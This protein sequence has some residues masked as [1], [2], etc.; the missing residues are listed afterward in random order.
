MKQSFP[1][2]EALTRFAQDVAMALKPGDC[3]LLRGD[4][5]AGKSTFARAAIRMLAGDPAGKLEVPS[6]TFTLVQTYDLRLPVSHFDLYR[7]GDPDE[8]DELGLTDA[9]AEGVALV[10]WPERAESR[11]PANSILFEIEETGESAD[12]REVTLTGPVEFMARLERSLSMRA[13]LQAHGRGDWFRR[14]LLGDASTRAYETVERGSDL[15]ILMNAPRR[16]DGPPVRDGKP[17]SQIAHLAEDIL[18]FVAIGR[19]LA[20]AGFRAP[21][22]HAFD[23]DQGFVLLE[24]LG[25]DGVLDENRMP[26][27]D[28]Y[29][30][31]VDCL[32]AMHARDWPHRLEVDGRAYAIADFDRDA[33]LIETELLTDWYLPRISGTKPSADAVAAFRDLWMELFAIVDAGEKTLLMRD[34]HSPNIIWDG[35][36]EGVARIG[37]IDFQDAMIGSTAYDVASII[38]DARVDI[39]SS[40]QNTLLDRYCAARTA[41]GGFDEAAFR[42]AFAIL[43]AQRA[44]KILGI[45]V[46]L[47]ERDGKPAYLG[48]IP[49]LQAYLRESLA[50]PALAGLAAWYDKY[51]ILDAGIGPRQ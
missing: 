8:L 44:T 42:L 4:L 18:P 49:R 29:A 21:Q 47:D 30:A 12:G 34:F 5:G 2:E 14:F 48:H 50:H 45:F 24:H 39:P 10:E 37:L 16:P 9:L 43:A 38:Q 19:H 40:L 26:L 3:L 7:L 20:E 25:S 35:S 15:L 51:G 33:F 31:A 11:L 13:F 36:A 41:Q 17:Y 1:S 22:I 23:L 46:R 32:A 6:P 28:R 27:P